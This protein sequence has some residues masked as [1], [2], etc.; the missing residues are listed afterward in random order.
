MRLKQR[1]SRRPRRKRRKP[2]LPNAMLSTPCREF[3]HELQRKRWEGIRMLEEHEQR[4]REMARPVSVSSEST[5]TESGAVLVSNM[6][7]CRRDVLW[8]RRQLND[9]SASNT[10]TAVADPWEW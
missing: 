3:W 8:I 9:N 4:M 7:F 5:M 10:M 1:P 2:V 6:K